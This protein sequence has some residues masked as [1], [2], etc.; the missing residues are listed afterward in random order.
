MFRGLCR[1]DVA[2]DFED[3]RQTVVAFVTGVF[4]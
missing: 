2:I 3:T 4:M 1:F